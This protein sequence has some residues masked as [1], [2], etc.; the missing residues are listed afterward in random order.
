[1]MNLNNNL[2]NVSISY[3]EKEL[4][5]QLPKENVIDVLKIKPAKKVYNIRRIISHSITNPLGKMS[6]NDRLQEKRP[7]RIVVIVEDMTRPNHKDYQEILSTI[8]EELENSGFFNNRVY[9]VIAYGTHRK[10]TY[11][12]N[13]T[14]Y[15][16]KL[17]K[18]YKFYHH[19]CDHD[20]VLLGNLSTGTPLWVNQQ[21]AEADFIIATGN[22]EPHTFA[23]YSGG[24]KAILP[25]VAGR[26]TI[27]ANHAK[28][29]RPGV[30]LGRLEGNPIHTEIVEAAERLPLDF[31]INFIR[32]EK[33]EIVSIVSGGMKK[34]FLEGVKEAKTYLGVEVKHRADVVISSSG[35]YPRDINLYLSQKAVTIANEVIT[36][37]GTIVLIAECRE[38]LGQ[39][40]FAKWITQN[41]IKDIL[42]K[43]EKEVEVEG[44]RAYL[45]AQILA[46]HEVILVSSL[47]RKTVES[48]HFTWA[49]DLNMAIDIV[50]KKHG[51]S[52]RSYIIPDASHILPI[53]YDGNNIPR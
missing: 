23:G 38:G 8:L 30:G 32:N 18:N 12:E 31:I 46:K 49:K 34:A 10:H 29:C 4:K 11:K 26:E 15:G 21:V 25:G 47:D 52:F 22:I 51:E 6:L 13:E 1:M 14:I 40:I 33:K 53:V 9:V 20:I 36:P 39:H 16:K 5:L 24:A 42:A 41:S 28:V 17:L 19:D 27:T 45:T 50:K 35:G 43:K 37:N 48:A 7:R 44:H 3:G 2:V